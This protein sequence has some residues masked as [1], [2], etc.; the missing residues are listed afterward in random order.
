MAAG[1]A[2]LRNSFDGDGIFFWKVHVDWEHPA[3]T[4]ADGPAK[5]DVAPNRHLCNGQLTSCVSQPDTER[6][7]DVQGNKIMQPLVYRRVGGHESIIAAHSI[8]TQGGGVRR[9]EFRLNKKRDP[10]LYQEGSY[11]P[12]GFYRWM[13]S[14][15][16]DEKG[17][18]GM[19]TPTAEGQT[20]PVSASPHEK[21]AI[22]TRCVG[23]ITP[24]RLWI[25]ATT[26]RSSMLATT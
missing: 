7:L 9:Y 3:N 21:P 23:R 15:A 24:R 4:K 17:D 26:A 11:A 19:D 2:W 5:I 12:G 14:V 25:R 1:G 22:P 8:A 16:M 6:R 10:V 13:P 20:F 18:I